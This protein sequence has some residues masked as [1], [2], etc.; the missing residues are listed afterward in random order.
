LKPTLDECDE[1]ETSRL[2]GAASWALASLSLSTLMPSLDTSIANVALPTLERS[3]AASFQEVQWIVLAYLL[4]I[5]TLIVGVGRLGDVIGRRRLLLAG[6]LLFTLASLLCGIAPTLASLIAARAAQGLG[7][8]VMMALTVA[9]VRETVPR[10]RM[11]STMGLLGSMSAIGTSLGP[12]LGGMLIGAFGWRVIFL[13]NIP[14]GLAN[15]LL[16][17]RYLPVDRPAMKSDGAR[18]DV[19]GTFLLALT[20]AAYALATTVGGGS[21]GPANV[22]LL[23]AAALGGGLFVLAERRAA[24]PLLRLAMFRDPTLSA[25]LAMSLIVAAVAI[26]TLVVG[27]F[28]LSRALGLEA[29]RVGLVMSVG[30]LVAALTGVPAGRV[31]DRLGAGRI[32]LIGLLGMAAGLFGLSLM[33]TGFGVA[34]Y[35]APLVIVTVGYALFQAANGTAVMTDVSA[36]RR[37]VV[38]GMLSLSRNL[39]LITGT[40]VL[41]AVFAFASGTSEIMTATPEAVALG[42]RITFAVAALLIVAALAIAAAGRAFAVRLAR[43]PEKWPHFSDKLTTGKADPV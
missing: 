33:P 24:S 31:V 6:I 21:F 5:T 35:L 19:V 41:G 13:V 16:A 25:G 29:A 30:P 28:Y 22:A 42:M 4:A 14:I 23:A 3:F 17:Q 38:S 10:A 32:T 1:A 37:G 36:E 27:S 9:L 11:G 39:G 15:L 18:F 12:S 40:S 43:D 2:T 26:T 20:L 7:A 34:G 8:A